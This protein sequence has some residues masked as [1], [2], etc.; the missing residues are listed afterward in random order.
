MVL[1]F[2]LPKRCWWWYYFFAGL[3]VVSV[4]TKSDLVADLTSLE[5]REH[6]TDYNMENVVHDQ[7]Q[8]S[9]R[10]RLPPLPEVA[11]STKLVDNYRCELEPWSDESMNP[12][13][14]RPL[15]EKDSQLLAVWR[16]IIS[17]TA[18]CNSDRRKRANSTSSHSR[19]FC[20][21][22]PFKFD[23]TRLRSASFW[24]LARQRGRRTTNISR[25]P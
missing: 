17:R 21:C 6:L 14:V 22:L 24:R 25:S 8:L 3:P 5:M 23:Y 1:C 7:C 9:H 13:S 2:G 18:A 12:S 19:A 4:A 10:G 20:R 11:A 15:P 16:D